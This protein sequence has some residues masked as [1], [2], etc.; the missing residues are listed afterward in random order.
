M[1]KI[2]NF[3]RNI[4]RV[5]HWLPIIWNDRDWD[6]YHIY[7][8]LKQKLIRTERHIREDGLHVYHKVDA[9]EIKKA[10]KMIEV[11]Q[12]E[13][14]LDKYLSE[15]N[16]WEDTGMAKSIEDH[17]KARHE[18]FQYLSDNIEKWWD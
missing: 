10:I 9:D 7:E 4:K 13:Y 15:T 6:Y 18:L 8:M 12:Y 17:D 1:Y 14:F 5:L 2:K 3:I 16:S 11:V